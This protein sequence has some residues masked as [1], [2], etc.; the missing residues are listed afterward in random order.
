M[1]SNPKISLLVVLFLSTLAVPIFIT[2]CEPSLPDGAREELD[3]S[4]ATRVAQDKATMEALATEI[5]ELT[6]T[7]EPAQA[8]S[9]IPLTPSPVPPT[10]TPVVV[11]VTATLQDTPTLAPPTPTSAPTNTPAPPTPTVPSNTPPDSILEV[12]ESWYQNGVRLKLKETNLAADCVSVLFDLYNETD[13]QLVVVM[14]LEKIF[15]E[16]NLDRRWSPVSLSDWVICDT[17]GIYTEKQTETVDSSDNFGAHWIGFEG[18]VT[19]S[20]VT[21]VIVTVEELS[22]ISN[23]RWRIPVYH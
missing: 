23:A 18:P 1:S 16:D 17:R 4:E 21:E 13:H 3:S 9:T 19:D 8:T 12:G 7:Q 15:A 10:P 11:V 6:E 22:Q 20:R 2:G 14:D 5:A